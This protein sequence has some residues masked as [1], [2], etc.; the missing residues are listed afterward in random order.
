MI[1]Y[2]YNINHHVGTPKQNREHY[3]SRCTIYLDLG[4]QDYSNMVIERINLRS[5]ADLSIDKVSCCYFH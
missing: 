2:I 1:L 4:V 3:E 5:I